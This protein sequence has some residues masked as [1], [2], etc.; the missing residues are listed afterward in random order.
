LRKLVARNQVATFAI[1]AL[2]VS[3]AAGMTFGLWEAHAALQ[4][5]GVA[6]REAGKASAVQNFLLEIFRANSDSNQD[7][8]KS[9]STTARELLDIGTQRALSDSTAPPDVLET[10]LGTLSDMYG[11]LGLESE[12]AHLSLQRIEALKRAY[13]ERDPRV[14]DEEI[15]A[16]EFAFPEDMPAALRHLRAATA[17]LDAAGDTASSVRGRELMDSARFQVAVQPA[18]ARDAADAACEFF[19][20]LHPDD[21]ALARALSWAGRARYWLGDYAGAE[22]LYVQALAQ[23]RRVAPTYLQGSLTH[24]LGLAETQF[25]LGK[26]DQAEAQMRATLAESI[27]RNGTLHM[28]TVHTETRLG[29]V[30]HSTSRRVE[31]RQLL[32]NAAAKVQGSGLDNLNL[33]LPVYR[34]LGLAQLADGRIE[35]AEKSLAQSLAL[36]RQIESPARLAW[37]LDDEAALYTE[38]GRF[39]EAQRLLGEASATWQRIAGDS[40]DPATFNRFHLDLGNLLLARGDPD[41]ALESFLRVSAPRDVGLMPLNIDAMRA[42]IGLAN[43]YLQL[44]R[45]AEAQQLAQMTRDTL[46]HSPIRSYYQDLESDALLVLGRAQ[47]HGVPAGNVCALVDRARAL[48]SANDDPGSPRLAATEVT[49]AEC[50]LARGD[51]VR[52]R[53]LFAQARSID[54]AH[55]ELGAQ[56]T[57]PLRELETHLQGRSR[58]FAGKSKSSPD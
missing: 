1:A 21:E 2:V 11:E 15:S 44:G 53:H 58:T 37:A 8:L 7:P 5:A 40:A 24:S 4:Q 55:R 52:A 20:R 39:A 45:S 19:R 33:Q 13:G 47:L 31:G 46:A 26:I 27:H 34:N 29:A 43:T 36:N 56:Y 3:L 22:S 42:A 38:L 51:R 32:Q 57:R 14:A 28:D 6:K 30:L 17:I 9:R 16:A 10:V 35:Q 54:A 50:V 48:R 41:A 23:T 25:A 12:A 49:L 18:A